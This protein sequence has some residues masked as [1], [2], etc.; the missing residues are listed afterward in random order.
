MSSDRFDIRGMLVLLL[1]CVG[2]PLLSGCGVTAGRSAAT[3][4]TAEQPIV[5]SGASTISS[6]LIGENPLSGDLVPVRDPSMARQGDGLYLFSTDTAPVPPGGFLPIRCSKDDGHTW[7]A[8]GHVFAERPGWTLSAVPGADGFWAPDISFFNGAWH[9]YYAISTLTG[10]ASAIGLATSPTLN[11]EDPAYGWT[12]HG[13]VIASG[14]SSDFNAIDPNIVLDASGAP[15]LSYG[16][17]WTGIYQ[18]AIDPT[19]GK[20]ASGTS[21]TRI[22]YKPSPS[23]HPIEASSILEHNGYYYLFAATGHCCASTVA[24]SDYEEIVGRSPSPHGPF[25]DEAGED[26]RNGGGTV[27]VSAGPDW[28]AP[29]SATAFHDPSTGKDML[30]FHALQL[31]QAGAATLWIRDISWQDDWPVLQ[32]F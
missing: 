8:C 22:A 20:L 19:T 11:P 30:A 12:D 27:L 32:S 26:M 5:T 25:V 13:E 24:A 18:R 2:L 7:T 9:L 17:F 23:D 31:S 3:V 29:G 1:C 28:F 4:S 15:F 10:K 6:A 14:G 16:S 21:R